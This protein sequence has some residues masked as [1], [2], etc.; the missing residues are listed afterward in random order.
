ME[1]VQPPIDRST[2]MTAPTRNVFAGTSELFL[3]EPY[4]IEPVRDA[5]GFARLRH[6]WGELLERSDAGLFNAWEWLYPWWQRIGSDR[7]PYRPGWQP[8]P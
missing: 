4:V 3:S 7:E 2:A 5:L 1:T 8:V 6:E